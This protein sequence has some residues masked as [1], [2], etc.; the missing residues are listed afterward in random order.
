MLLFQL[1]RFLHCPPPRKPG[2][3]SEME[4]E[5]LSVFPSLTFLC[6]LVVVSKHFGPNHSFT[7][8]WMQNQQHYLPFAMF[9]DEIQSD[10]G[11]PFLKTCQARYK[12][13]GGGGW[14]GTNME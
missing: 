6:S 4:M 14:N 11:H 3:A 8:A 9:L 5:K 13:G 7:Q 12:D 1:K 2:Q 10:S